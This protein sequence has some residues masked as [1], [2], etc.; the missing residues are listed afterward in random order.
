MLGRYCQRTEAHQEKAGEKMQAE[1]YLKRGMNDPNRVKVILEPA[2]DRED[3]GKRTGVPAR[4][5]KRAVQSKEDQPKFG[6]NGS[7]LSSMLA[8]KGDT[9]PPPRS[10]QQR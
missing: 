2:R 10:L 4:A 6:C 3:S 8:G 1:W 9:L 7:G 5:N